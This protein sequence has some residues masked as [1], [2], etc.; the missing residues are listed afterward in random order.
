MAMS[1]SGYLDIFIEGCSSEANAY[2]PVYVKKPNI[3]DKSSYMPFYIENPYYPTVGNF[4]DISISGTGLPT[5]KYGWIDLYTRGAVESK[6]SYIPLY[7]LAYETSMWLPVYVRTN[8]HLTTF[9]QIITTYDL[10]TYVPLYLST[11]NI[12]RVDAYIPMS[13]AGIGE[14]LGLANPF[15][16]TN[17]GFLVSIDQ[18]DPDILQVG[19]SLSIANRGFLIKGGGGDQQFT[20]YKNRY[21]NMSISGLSEEGAWIPPIGI[22]APNFGIEEVHTMYSGQSYDFGSPIGVSS[23][24]DAGNGPYTHYVDNTHPSSTDTNNTYGTP[25]RPRSTIPLYLTSGN[26]VE[27][28]GGP[29]NYYVAGNPCPIFG[30]GTAAAPIFVRGI[31]LPN[32]LNICSTYDGANLD[33]THQYIIIEGILFQGFD[34]IAPANHICIRN[35]ETDGSLAGEPGWGGLRVASYSFDTPSRLVNNVVFYHNTVHDNMDWLNNTGD[36][37]N[38]GI[39]VGYNCSYIWILE[40]TIYHCEGDGVQITVSTSSHQSSVN[41]IYVGRN[42]AYENK[43]VGFWCKYSEDVIF[44]ENISHDHR[45]SNT[46][47]GAGMGCQYGPAK[48]WW[49]YNTIYNCDAGISMASAN[50]GFAAS[51]YAIGNIIYNIHGSTSSTQNPDETYNAYAFEANSA[52]SN[53]YA[54]NNTIVNCDGGIRSTTVGGSTP[55]NIENNIISNITSGWRHIEVVNTASANDTI[56]KNCL[57]YQSGNPITIKWVDTTYTSISEF[58]SATSKG[59]NCIA[60]DPEFIDIIANNFELSS[61][62]PAVDGGILSD[63]YDTFYSLYTIDIKKDIAGSSRPRGDWDIGAYENA[64]GNFTLENYFNLY[65]ACSSTP[66]DLGEKL[67]WIKMDDDPT[68]GIDDSSGKNN[69]GIYISGTCPTYLSNS[70]HDGLGAYSFNGIDEY[71]GFGD[72]GITGIESSFTVTAWIDVNTLPANNMTIINKWNELGA[73]HS[74][75]SFDIVVTPAGAIK[76]IVLQNAGGTKYSMHRSNENIIQSSAGWQHIAVAWEGGGNWRFYISGQDAGDV[77]VYDVG[78]PT[79]IQDTVEPLK[80]GCGKE[81]DVLNNYFDGLIDDVRV[82][83]SS[84]SASQISGIYD[85]TY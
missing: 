4:C 20:Q 63:V 7:T 75:K 16:F 8:R 38:H 9:A 55:L 33:N 17:R 69:S 19:N 59:Q 81:S 1:L 39:G 80:I 6:S 58:Q 62:S 3:I 29:Y 41:H 34:I 85:G 56:I 52:G 15:S 51:G 77:S 14:S 26:V 67:L 5:D 2:L 44:S 25:D 66:E 72:I 70:G 71:I 82:Y 73:D 61:N 45:Q 64:S 54:I 48:I 36:T 47:N 37:D 83:Q 42:I 35:C 49:L 10:N 22:P 65:T 18:N 31:G 12:T 68:D 46:A 40:N 27:V 79:V 28:H 57:L 53:I 11:E 23:Y 32:L 74:Q 50:D 21:L 13:I 24:P 30:S 60:N 76:A 84:L 43:Q 78:V